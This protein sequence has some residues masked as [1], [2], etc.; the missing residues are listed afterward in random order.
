MRATYPGAAA[1][2]GRRQ[3][4]ADLMHGTA[5]RPMRPKVWG[6]AGP[7]C[8]GEHPHTRR[9]SWACRAC[10]ARLTLGGASLP[11]GLALKLGERGGGHELFLTYNDESEGHKFI[12]V[13][14]K[15]GAPARAWSCGALRDA[16]SV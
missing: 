9:G 3:R 6:A 13:D 4:M 1:P 8:R 15:S 5:L 2:S 16:A 11:A 10:G 12:K 14:T 7:C